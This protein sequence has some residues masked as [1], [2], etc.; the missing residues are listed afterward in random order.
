MRSLKPSFVRNWSHTAVQALGVLLILQCL[1]LLVRANMSQQELDRLVDES[2]LV[3]TGKMQQLGSNVDSLN[4]KDGA[5][6]VKVE[7]V[8]SSRPGALEKFGSLTNTTLTVVADL[9]L[10]IEPPQQ[11]TTVVFFVNPLMYERNIAVSALAISEVPG[12]S[13]FFQRLSTAVQRK[14]ERPLKNAVASSDRIVIGTVK[15]IRALPE[16]E[17]SQLGLFADG[18]DI[19][20]EH[21]P[22]WKEALI[23]VQSVLKGEPDEK[24]VIV[25]FPST[26]DRMWIDSPKFSVGQDGIW[27]L[28]D[29]E[30]AKP[31]VKILLAPQKFRGHETKAYTTLNP[32]DFL[33]KDPAGKNEARIREIIK[34]LSR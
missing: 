27:L 7:E 10:G 23:Q 9:L 20:S 8:K 14:E 30:V 1:T 28:H 15:E 19:R 25:V 17:S 31:E 33:P 26:D 34:S 21:S 16:A 6:I 3:F 12:K 5:M 29:N 2:A 32:E 24:M 13:D 22:R 18:R 11:D 4:E